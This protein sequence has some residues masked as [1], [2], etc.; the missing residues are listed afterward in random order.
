MAIYITIDS[1]T[2]NTRISIIN[3]FKIID[4]LKFAV[5]AKS[6]IENKSVLIN[7]MKNGICEWNQ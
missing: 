7:T 4:T 2:T 3:N 5:G 1:G 6:G